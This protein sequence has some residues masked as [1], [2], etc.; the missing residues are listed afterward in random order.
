MENTVKF[1]HILFVAMIKLYSLEQF[2][3]D[4]IP[5]SI[6]LSLLLLF[7]KFA[8]FPFVFYLSYQYPYNL[9]LLF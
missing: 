5:Y 7:C 2:P 8:I 3:L 9:D 6:M 1:V 4:N